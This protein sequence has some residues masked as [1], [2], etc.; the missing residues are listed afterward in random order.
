MVSTA[1]ELLRMSQA[2]LDEL[3][4]HSPSGDI[5]VGDTE[6]TVI[7]APGTDLSGPAARFAKWLAWRGKVFDP[8]S[9]TLANK[10][11]AFDIHAIKAQ[12]YKAT[13]WFDGQEAIILDYSR[14]SVVAHR[15][16]DEIREVAPGLYLG[17]V[18]LGRARVLNFALTARNTAR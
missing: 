16:R 1:T 5:P 17:Q 6:G 10:I 13:S 7:V 8:R 11:T 9:K 4:R 14:K 12:V 18:F 15:I 2:D 3:F